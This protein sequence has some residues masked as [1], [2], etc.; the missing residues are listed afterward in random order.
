[1]HAIFKKSERQPRQPPC[2]KQLLAEQ[3]SRWQLGTKIDR[4]VLC[5]LA[6][7]DQNALLT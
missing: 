1:M 5:A 6:C 3:A 7:E 2:P 4:A